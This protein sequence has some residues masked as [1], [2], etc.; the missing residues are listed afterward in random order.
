[1][2]SNERKVFLICGAAKVQNYLANAS[3]LTKV[4]HPFVNLKQKLKIECNFNK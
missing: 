2:L 4:M 1:M 3:S